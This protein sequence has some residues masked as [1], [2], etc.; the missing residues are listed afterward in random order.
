[1]IVYTHEVPYHITITD[2]LLSRLHENNILFKW[3]SP[4]P[5]DGV[6]GWLKAGTKINLPAEISIEE[7]SGLY[8]GPYRGLVGGGRSSGIV[9]IGSFSYSYS[10]LPDGIKIGR[11][12][13]IS[14]GLRILDSTHPLDTVTTSALMFRPRNDLYKHHQTDAVRGF[15]KNFKHQPDTMPT[16]GHDVWIGADVTLSPNID[17][18]TGA[19][20][21]AGS[22]VTKNV[23]PY[24]I[25]GGNPAKPIR[26]RFG[27]DVAQQLLNSEWWAYDPFD[28]FEDDPRDVSRLLERIRN[29]E[30]KRYRPRI[31]KLGPLEEEEE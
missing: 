3:N 14:S 2:E 8:R 28:I 20:I 12:C 29:N 16:I 21:A 19:V 1:M 31:L 23:E 25:V 27:D 10:P 24:M 15:A 4:P 18:G 17:I 13:S 5:K 30:L 22:I 26:R 9:P 7:N 11:Y 6:Y